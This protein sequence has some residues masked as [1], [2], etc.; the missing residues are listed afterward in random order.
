MRA[1]SIWS[2]FMIVAT[3]CT[4]VPKYHSTGFHVS[5]NSNPYNGSA[6]R[7]STKA[8]KP[9]LHSNSSTHKQIDL[10]QATSK[11]AHTNS[12]SHRKTV[13][14]SATQ[15][16]EKHP[17]IDVGKGSTSNFIIKSNRE[18]VWDSKTQWG[19]N[20]L[21]GAN[22]PLGAKQPW[23]SAKSV[24]PKKTLEQLDLQLRQTEEKIR[25]N[26]EGFALLLSPLLINASGR[27]SKFIRG[28]NITFFTLSFLCFFF[29]IFYCIK[30]VFQWSR[31]TILRHTRK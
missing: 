9:N 5:W 21:W 18:K 22:Q 25:D 20:H 1:I 7:G 19:A 14:H 29:A 16:A 30:Y 2:L 11:S 10:S 6:T 28:W 24:R 17:S 31:F 13:T 4:L 26:F 23:D 8:Q 15:T 12:I 3:G 27:E